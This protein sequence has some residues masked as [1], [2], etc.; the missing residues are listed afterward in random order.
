MESFSNFA[1]LAAPGTVRR[2]KAAPLRSS[3]VAAARLAV[4]GCMAMSVVLPAAAKER[5][6][7]VPAP[8]P[9][10]M[11]WRLPVPVSPLGNQLTQARARLGQAL[12]FDPRLS[13]NGTMSCATCHNP[14]FGWSDGLKTAIGDGGKVLARATPT[15]VNTAFNTQFMWDGRKDSLED[16]A[17]GPMKASDEMNTDVP[18]MLKRLNA[19]GGYGAMF[20]RAY[21]GEGITEQSLA[22]AIAAFERTVVVRDSRFDQWL[23]GDR[24]ALT[25]SEWRGYKVFSDPDKGNCAACH[26]PPNFTDNGFHNIGLRTVGQADPGRYRI[27]KVA[28]MLG[29]FKTP[30]LRGIELTAPYFRDGSA[31]TL[32]EVVDH[33]DRG[34][35]DKT[36]LSPNMKPLRLTTQEK[37]DLVG[38]M[39][40]L[41]GKARDVVLPP[42]PQ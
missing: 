8:S 5:P 22:K 40:A 13:G 34:G 23:Q 39:K 26:A 38:F 35:E 14:A 15:V 6:V 18:G 37:A 1:P 31:A 9:G 36:N 25:A 2:F 7:Q 28:S 19:I 4:I 30:T 27:R 11:A 3:V 21:P 24:R 12:F 10:D 29:A 42:L 20:E 41:T 33:Y 16:Q 32:E 17:L